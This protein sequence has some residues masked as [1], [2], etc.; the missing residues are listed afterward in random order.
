MHEKITDVLK[1]MKGMDDSVTE[2]EV[3]VS[4]WRLTK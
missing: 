3:K 4:R 1:G 2:L